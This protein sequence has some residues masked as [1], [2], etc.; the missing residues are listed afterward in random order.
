MEKYVSGNLCLY[1]KSNRVKKR[2]KNFLQKLQN[3]IPMGINN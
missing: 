3:M 1:G 2:S